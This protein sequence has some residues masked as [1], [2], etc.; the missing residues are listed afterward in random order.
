MNTIL[1]TGATGYLGRHIIRQLLNERRHVRAL[2]RDSKKLSDFTSSSLEIVE[3]EVTNPESL[4]GLM[5]GIDTVISTVGITRQK[6]GLSYEQV[7]YEANRN[8]L[9]EAI[10]SGVRKFIFVSVLNGQHL[11]SL[12]ICE[13]KERF[14]ETLKSSEIE[15][16]VIRP[17][18]FFSDMKEFLEMARKGRVYVFGDGDTRSNPIHGE[19]LA[20]VCI[21]AIESSDSEIGAGGPEVFS[22]NEIARLAFE[23]V[24]KPVAI[25]RIPD[26]F[27]RITLGVLRTFTPVSVY[28]PLEF[29]LTVLSMDMLAP[30]TGHKRLKDFFSEVVLEY[31]RESLIGEES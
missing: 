12:K 29:F 31:Q 27:R 20:R 28:G 19:D 2:S 24:N 16:A 30:Q 7:D 15:Y 18:G 14:V 8:L 4:R 9:N 22:Q 10:A 13:A 25:T 5:K 6:D 1:V 11:K 26:V 3:A 23:S 21:K 17:N